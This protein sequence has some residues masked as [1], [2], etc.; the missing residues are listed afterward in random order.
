M[1]Q[2]QLKAIM[3]NS[4]NLTLM[5]DLNCGKMQWE[6]WYIEGSEDSWRNKL[7][8]NL[9]MKNALTQW[10]GQETRFRGDTR[11]IKTGPHIHKKN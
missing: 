8:M 5:G 11:T 2:T 9:T 3:E 7:T 1:I 4:H 6:D 10:A